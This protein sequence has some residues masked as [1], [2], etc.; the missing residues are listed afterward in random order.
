M[1]SSLLILVMLSVAVVV[2]LCTGGRSTSVRD[3]RPY[4]IA[5]GIFWVAPLVLMFALHVVLPD[6]NAD[7]RCT[8][9]GFGCVPP[10]ADG[11]VF[12]WGLT[13]PFTFTAGLIC[14]AIIAAVRRGRREP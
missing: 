3:A 13:L 7:G 4:L 5:I 1:L 11:V 10:P 9:L 8:G 12:L 14:C 6:H 2:A